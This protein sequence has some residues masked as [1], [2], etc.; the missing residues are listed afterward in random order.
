[1]AT[2]SASLA[3]DIRVTSVI[4]GGHMFSH[5]YFMVFG[6]IMPL[7]AAEL[8]FTYTMLAAILSAYSFASF[9]VQ[10][11]FGFLVDK[12]G[13]RGPLI[14]GLFT[15][16]ASIAGLGFAS[17]F[18]H[19][20]VLY[21]IA[22]MANSVF[23]P[24]DYAILSAS[25]NNSR[26]GRAFGVHLFSGHFAWVICP[27]TMLGAAALWGWRG[28]F[29]SVGLVGVAYALFMLTQWSALED[30]REAR[31]AAKMKKNE[32][33]NSN[34]HD[35]ESLVEGIR[36]LLTFPI[37]MCMLFFVFLT[38][39]FTGIRTFFVAAME[40]M[41]GM[42]LANSNGALTGFIIG[43]TIGI[44]AGGVL[45]DKIGPKIWLAAVSLVGAGI[46]IIVSGT[47]PMTTVMLFTIMTLAGTFLGLLLPSRDLLV[48]QVTPDGS[49]GKVMGFLSTGMM[50]AAA[51]A[52]LIFGYFL[53]LGQPIWVFWIS[54]IFVAFA[55]FTFVSTAQRS[56]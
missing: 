22:G 10:T 34:K 2:S 37:V 8:N 51:V 26:M 55:L 46:L 52:P 1:M 4:S 43:S 45:A 28:A 12:Y 19:F 47:V 17:E 14:L 7:L 27:G 15:M 13:A 38:L 42:S 21:S 9:A 3:R 44:T 32:E 5:Y 23:H 25:V 49:M 36:L 53:D 48:R 11:P 54:G 6:P 30:G 31:A 35:P 39:G 24:A 16:G 40:V 41:N 33:N 56:S 29:V 50:G 20:L 18:W